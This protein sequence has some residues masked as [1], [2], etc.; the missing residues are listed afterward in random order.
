VAEQWISW[1]TRATDAGGHA[2]H[3]LVP[4]PRHKR[5]QVLKRRTAMRL[6]HLEDQHSNRPH[7]RA[8]SRPLE[9][10]SAVHAPC[11]RRNAH[12][13]QRLIRRRP[14]RIQHTPY[15]R[16]QTQAATTTRNTVEGTREVVNK[17]MLL[18][19]TRAG[20]CFRLMHAC[21]EQAFAGR[22][23]WIGRARTHSRCEHE[24]IS[25]WRGYRHELFRAMR[26]SGQEH[27]VQLR[28]RTRQASV[29]RLESWAKEVQPARKPAL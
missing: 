21:G 28:E 15:P 20:A 5:L 14:L 3:S 18:G 6:V 4:G 22:P 1:E 8:A 19:Y 24:E 9:V 13:L 26:F 25:I 27:W 10:A 29:Q 2:S 11:G 17:L 12:P 7:L 23:G 16:E